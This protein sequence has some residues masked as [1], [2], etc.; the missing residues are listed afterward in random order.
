[1]YFTNNNDQ[2]QHL[3]KHESFCK[4]QYEIWMENFSGDNPT[5]PTQPEK[6]D[7]ETAPR[8]NLDMS[9]MSAEQQAAYL[10]EQ[11]TPDKFKQ[12]IVRIVSDAINKVP[13]N[14]FIRVAT[15]YLRI[16][17]AVGSHK[18]Q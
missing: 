11:L 3:T 13:D 10:S 17:N 8:L 18:F 1:M 14:Q 6:Q 7:W 15:G 16:T 2:N 9:K 5:Q 4:N 12:F